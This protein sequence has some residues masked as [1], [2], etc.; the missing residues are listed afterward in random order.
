MKASRLHRLFPVLLVVGVLHC[1]GLAHAQQQSDAA[2]DEALQ[3]RSTITLLE[4]G[5]EPRYQLRYT[6]SVGDVQHVR[7]TQNMKMKQ[8]MGDMNMPEMVVPETTYTMKLTVKEVDSSTGH[9]TYDMECVDASVNDS[10]GANPMMVNQLQRMM[11]SMKQF[12]G[13]Y[14]VNARGQILK[15]DTTIPE[16]LDPTV[17]RQM[18]SIQQSVGDFGTAFPEAKIGKGAKWHSVAEV[19]ATGITVKHR[20]TY[21]VE[22]ITE[23]SLHASI[24]I[25][26]SADPQTVN[27]PG[28]PPGATM[29]LESMDGAG[30]GSVQ[31]KTTTLLPTTSSMTYQQQSTMTMS[32]R[33][34]TQTIEQELEMSMDLKTVDGPDESTTAGAEGDR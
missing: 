16:N 6:C 26:Q 3:P 7:F 24:E 31:Y 5:S 13:S 27:A 32:A 12:S 18:E 30:D 25:E 28:M 8:S 29:K 22:S 4:A 34:N 17:R 1:T 23:D 9:I 10:P 33:G 14:I 15:A 19:A 20:T 2:D 21:T 11:D